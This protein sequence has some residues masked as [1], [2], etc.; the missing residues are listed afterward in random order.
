[1][2]PQEERVNGC[3]LQK[4]QKE[5]EDAGL[6]R[7]GTRLVHCVVRHMA[8]PGARLSSQRTRERGRGDGRVSAEAEL[9]GACWPWQACL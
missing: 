9:S 2:Q 6:L 5:T 1:M 3:S 7:A 8:S 4:E